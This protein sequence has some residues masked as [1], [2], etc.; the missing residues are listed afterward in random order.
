MSTMLLANNGRAS[1]SKRTRHINIRYF[2]I[3][4]R[5]GRREIAIK[6][7]PTDDMIADFY[8]KPLNGSKFCK[9]RNLIMNCGNDVDDDTPTSLRVPITEN[10]QAE[11]NDPIPSHTYKDALIGSQECV[12]SNRT[13]RKDVTKD[14]RTSIIKGKG[15]TGSYSTVSYRSRRMRLQGPA[16]LSSLVANERFGGL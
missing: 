9:F 14:G 7:C 16:V 1:S 12:G 15:T 6:Y 13:N 10:S 4:D 11:L 2:F 3:T 5:I 8:T